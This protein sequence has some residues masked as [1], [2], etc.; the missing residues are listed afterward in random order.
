MASQSHNDTFIY[1]FGHEI[2]PVYDMECDRVSRIL[3]LGGIDIQNPTG[4]QSKFPCTQIDFLQ[5]VPS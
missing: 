3:V 5:E 1:K 2:Y 4:D